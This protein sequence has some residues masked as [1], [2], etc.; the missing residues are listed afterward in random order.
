MSETKVI[1]ERVSIHGLD[2]VQ[3]LNRLFVAAGLVTRPR[4]YCLED[5]LSYLDESDAR[6][7]VTKT[8]IHAFKGRIIAC[9]LSKDW[10]DP[11]VFDSQGYSRTFAQ[12]VQTMRIRLGLLS[13]E[14]FFSSSCL[15]SACFIRMKID[16]RRT[17]A[18]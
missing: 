11:L 9:D 5:T 12:I 17:N 4:I 8:Y 10:V 3:L 13:S 18:R 7:L 1:N 14:V 16:Q 15:R 2:K 6:L